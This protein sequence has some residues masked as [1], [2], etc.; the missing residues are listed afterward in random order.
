MRFL[1]GVNINVCMDSHHLCLQARP[2]KTKED[3]RWSTLLKKI[4]Q[5]CKN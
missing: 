5:G 4:E 3:T 2:V 1:V